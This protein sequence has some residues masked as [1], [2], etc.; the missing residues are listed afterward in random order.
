MAKEKVEVGI[1]ELQALMERA[2]AA[3]VEAGMRA[4]ALK[5]EATAPHEARM[6][7]IKAVMNGWR[8]PARE[9]RYECVRSETGAT[10]TAVI[11]ASSTF[12]LGRVVRIEDYAHPADLDARLVAMGMKTTKDGNRYVDA[13]TKQWVWAEFFREDLKRF[14]GK[15]L[16]SHDKAPQCSLPGDAAGS[17][18][19]LTEGH[20]GQCQAPAKLDLS[21]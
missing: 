14:V 13:I 19:R 10:F 8:P 1:D 17:R 16:P 6:E 4:A 2:T 5:P 11:A 20:S 3:G 21:A 7:E 15:P 18:C 9:E 12:P